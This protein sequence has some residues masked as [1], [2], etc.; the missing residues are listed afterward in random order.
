MAKKKI[1]EN[2]SIVEESPKPKIRAKKAFSLEDYME[3]T[4]LPTIKY[5][6][7]TWIPLSKAYQETTFLE[8]IP[9]NALTVIYGHMN[10][11]K[12]TLAIEAMVGAQ[13]IGV[14]PILIN[15]E[16]KFNWEHAEKMGL[17]QKGVIY[18]DSLET[19]EDCCSFIKEKLNDQK[20]GELAADILIVWDSIGNIISNAELKADEKGD[21]AA[22]MATAKVLTQQIHRII[23]KRISDTK[24]E[25][26]PYNAT[27]LV[28]NHAYQGTQAN[29][30]I[31]YG[32]QGALKAA[33]LVIRMGGIISN[34]TACY[35]VKN[36]VE[37]A[38]AIKTGITIEKNHITD[39]SVKA[40][41]ICTP[42][43]FVVNSTAALDEYKKQNKDDWELKYN[44]DWDK[45]DAD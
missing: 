16:K 36:G 10:S 25:T 13:K 12:S 19:A 39:L 5:K 32:G 1:E 20:N 26:F 3:K 17:D 6:E 30:L 14:V 15:T 34:S 45:Y 40:K 43:G 18:V 23:E 9:E 24:K 7:Q 41:I 21:T 11:G 31:P 27:L 35:A 2:N 37:V 8:G 33:T 29:T 22:M 42:K 4:K 38:Y 28:V 44:K